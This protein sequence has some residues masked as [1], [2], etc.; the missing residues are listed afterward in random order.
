MR[1]SVVIVT[2]NRR[3]ALR[4]TL[5]QLAQNPS[6][7]HGSMEVIVVDNGSTDGTRQEAS[8]D[9]LDIT[10]ITRTRNEGVWARNHAFEVAKGQY[11]LLIDDDSYPIG[12]AA[13]RSMAHLDRE[14]CVGAVVG[15]V[16]LPDGRLEASA[17]PTVVANGAVVLRKAV[18]DE[19]GGFPTDFFRQAEEYDLSLRIWNAG[20]RIDRFEDLIYRH[21]KV[22]GNRASALIHRLDMRNN[23]VVV[24]RYVPAPWRRAIRA[25]WAQRY[26]ALARHARCS[27]A[28][29]AG[30]AGA[31]WQS[32][33]DLR[34]R[35][36]PLS[37]AAFE[38]AFGFD[39]QARRIA[40][41]ARG[42]R[43]RRV[44]IADC[45]KNL[46]ATWRGCREAG[47]TILAIADDH[48]A[49]ADITY[50]GLRVV[51]TSRAAALEP[52]GVVLANV[53]PAQ[54]Q[55][56]ADELAGRFD[57][58]I[59]TLWQPQLL[60]AAAESSPDQPGLFRSDAA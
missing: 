34:D 19:V 48:P 7:P 10:C 20:W 29:L 31:R 57:G 51:D 52:D 36:Q 23:L 60:N 15:R 24:D 26:T 50:R 43:V 5:D 25:D 56:R 9:D 44:V 28:A 21:D 17:L 13:T 49:F 3:A 41:W 54:V 6:L 58:P 4:H 37:P 55:R 47:L 59:L 18:I 27:L 33:R 16:V 14:Q 1:L 53:N 22:A 12:D 30:R 32:V 2:C 8:R 46:L 45:A 38:S 35:R 39:G 40:E 42:H 11:I